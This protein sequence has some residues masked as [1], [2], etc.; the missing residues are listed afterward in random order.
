MHMLSRQCHSDNEC[1]KRNLEIKIKE[2]K[3]MEY[4]DIYIYL[5]D[6]YIYIL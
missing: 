1:I 2:I 6:I 4:L 5:L 3:M